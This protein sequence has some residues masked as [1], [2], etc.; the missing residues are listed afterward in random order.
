MIACDSPD[1]SIKWF[2]F[3]CGGLADAPSGKWICNECKGAPLHD[4]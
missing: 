3:E 2:H 4:G 1:C